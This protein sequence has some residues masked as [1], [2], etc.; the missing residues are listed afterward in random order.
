MI[1]QLD[2]TLRELLKSVIPELD[3]AKITF[4]AP[5]KQFDTDPAVNLFLYDVRG[6]LELRSNEWKSV[7]KN[8]AGLAAERMPPAVRVDC[9]T[10]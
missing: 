7:Q 2:S 8:G 6:N 10:W 5:T 4:A 9:R 3:D 1:D